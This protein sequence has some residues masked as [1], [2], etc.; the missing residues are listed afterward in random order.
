MIENIKISVV[1]PIFNNIDTIERCLDSIYSQTY[2]NYECILAD[3][4]S[5]VDYSYLQEKYPSLI[6]IR[7]PQNSGAG[8]AR[9]YA[10]DNA[11]TGDWV[12]FIDSDDEFYSRIV[13]SNFV[14][15]ANRKKD[16]GMIKGKYIYNNFINGVDESTDVGNELLIAL[17]GIFFNV[18]LLKENNIRF[19]D[20]LRYHEDVYFNLLCRYTFYHKYGNKSIHFTDSYYYKQNATYNSVTQT[21]YDGKDYFEAKYKYEA[22]MFLDVVDKLS[23]IISDEEKINLL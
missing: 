6:I 17:H 4:C 22:Q 7:L 11:V 13:F 9:Q 18:K 23:S 8:V 5:D 3:D 19:H 20:T 21:T 2:K 12:V 14:H 15:I 16:W 10:L 1:I